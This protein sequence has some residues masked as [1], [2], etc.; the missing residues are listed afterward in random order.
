M[1]KCSRLHAKFKLIGQISI[2]INFTFKESSAL[3]PV[4][5]LTLSVAGALG[6]PW[7]SDG[8]TMVQQAG[9]EPA[10]I[11][12]ASLQIH[13]ESAGLNAK[14]ISRIYNNKSVIC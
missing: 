3:V 14:G 9:E 10:I 11:Q 1:A 13:S 12:E 4:E 6:G 7:V 8:S 2:C 5:C